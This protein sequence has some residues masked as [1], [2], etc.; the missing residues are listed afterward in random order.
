LEQSNPFLRGHCTGWSLTSDTGGAPPNG[1]IPMAISH[2]TG[3][4]VTTQANPSVSLLSR[5]KRWCIALPMVVTSRLH[6]PLKNRAVRR[7]VALDR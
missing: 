1:Q 5:K 4:A 6:Q 7:A 3:V 2:Q